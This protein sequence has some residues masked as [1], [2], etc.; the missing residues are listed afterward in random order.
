MVKFL[1]L[2]S[3]LNFN[4]FIITNQGGIAKGIFKLSDFFKLHK[5]LK[6]YFLSKKDIYK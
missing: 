5:T 6:N 2:A 3:A 1:K 4:I